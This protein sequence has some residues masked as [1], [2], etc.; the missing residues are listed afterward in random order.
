MLCVLPPF[1][2]SG[3][4]KTSQSG[5][6]KHHSEMTMQVTGETNT[7]R[8]DVLIKNNNKLYEYTYYIDTAK[9]PR[10]KKDMIY[11]PGRVLNEIKENHKWRKNVT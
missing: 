9:I 11:H 10:W 6:T 4:A 5:A 7:G 2:G 3:V 1:K 8:L